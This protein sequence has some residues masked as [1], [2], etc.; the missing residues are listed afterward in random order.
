VVRKDKPF[1]KDEAKVVSGVCGVSEKL[2][3]LASYFF[4][5]MS[6]NSVVE[7]LRVKRFAVIQEEIC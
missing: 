5:S 4:S 6:S 7:E 3:I 1:I 2:C